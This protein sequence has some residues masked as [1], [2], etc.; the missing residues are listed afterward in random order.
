MNYDALAVIIDDV[1]QQSKFP[2]Q[3][4]WPRRSCEEEEDDDIEL[5]RWRVTQ[6][7]NIDVGD[8]TIEF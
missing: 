2:G 8:R 7:G 1:E 5:M 6:V 3:V 4:L